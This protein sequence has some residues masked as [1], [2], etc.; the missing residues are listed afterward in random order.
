MEAILAFLATIHCFP[1][2][3]IEEA[4]TTFYTNGVVYISYPITDA[5]LVHE[6]AHVCQDTLNG[7]PA[8]NWS[9]WKMREREAKQVEMMWLELKYK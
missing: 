9:E 7:G 2:L 3:H 6:L 5:K 8:Q 1:T 4:E